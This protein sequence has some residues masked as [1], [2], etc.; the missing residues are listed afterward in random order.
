L[1]NSVELELNQDKLLL[2]MQERS[3]SIWMLDN[4]D[5]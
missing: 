4:V 3:G 2:T 5:R 1:I